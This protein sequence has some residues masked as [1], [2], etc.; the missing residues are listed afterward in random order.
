M[1]DTITF[2]ATELACQT[3]TVFKHNSVKKE[4]G[5]FPCILLGNSPFF[6]LSQTPL[7]LSCGVSSQNLNKLP[8]INFPQPS[9]HQFLTHT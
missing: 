8:P 2:V 5:I 6:L 1:N 7:T 9:C 3:N 4:R